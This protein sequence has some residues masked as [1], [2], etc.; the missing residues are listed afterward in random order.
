MKQDTK[1]EKVPVS[2]LGATGV[3]GQRLVRL[4]ADH[5]WFEI[6]DLVASERSAGRPYGEAVRWVT[7]GAIPEKLA[8]REVSPPERR[9]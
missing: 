5:P 1:R 3:V 4:L 7:P 8:G 2:I 6:A 9:C